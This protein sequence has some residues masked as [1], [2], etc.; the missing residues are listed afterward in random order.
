MHFRPSNWKPNVVEIAYAAGTRSR[1]SGVIAGA[2]ED[3]VVFFWSRFGTT[4]NNENIKKDARQQATKI[5]IMI[6]SGMC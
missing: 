3:E 4:K 2:R 5:G 1:R 6:N